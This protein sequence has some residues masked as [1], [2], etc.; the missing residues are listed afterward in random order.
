MS[1]V[2]DTDGNEVAMFAATNSRV[3]N[4][5]PESLMTLTFLFFFF[6]PAYIF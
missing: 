4:S 6:K 3:E 2:A 5:G 1:T